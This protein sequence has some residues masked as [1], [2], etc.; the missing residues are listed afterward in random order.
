MPERRQLLPFVG[1]VCFIGLLLACNP[2]RQTQSEPKAMAS[3]VPRTPAQVLPITATAKLGDRL[4]ELEVAKTRQQQAIGLMYRT[5]LPS[6][7]GMLF[8]FSPPQSVQFWMKH[9]LIALDMIFVRGGKVVAIAPNTP[10]CKADPCPT[11]G[12]KEPIDR[13][14]EIRGGLAA[15]IGLKVGDPVE[16]QWLKTPR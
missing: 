14:I 7:R 1:V 2:I 15:S 12:P 3:A 6:N 11:Y 13:V 9:C 10:P 8:P 4:F 16:V 5:F